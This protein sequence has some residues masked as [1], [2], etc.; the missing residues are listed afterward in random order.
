MSITAQAV[1]TIPTLSAALGPAGQLCWSPGDVQE[2]AFQGTVTFTGDGSTATAVVNWIDGTQALPFTPSAVL[3]FLMP[4]GTDA[5]GVLAVEGSAASPRVTSITAS[6]AT[7]NY[8]TAIANTRTSKLLL[9]A[10]K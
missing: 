2:P 7:I 8:S 6:T 9:I 10:Y 5:T 1:T 3:V 4:G